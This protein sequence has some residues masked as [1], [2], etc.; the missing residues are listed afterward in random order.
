MT[1][2][3]RTNGLGPLLFAALLAS[4]I[5]QPAA[6]ID[7]PMWVWS[8][9]HKK[10]DVPA[11][12][13]YFRKTFELARPTSGQIQI[14]ADNAY[15]V[16]VNSQPVGRGGDWRRMNV[17]DISKA[18]VNGMN[19]VAVHV[20][21][22]DTGTAGLAARLIAEQQSD[23]VKV[24]LTDDTWRC[25]V[26]RYASWTQAAFPSEDWLAAQEFGPLGAT[27][28]WG[29]EVV[30]AGEGSRFTVPDGF[31]IERSM[32]H[33]EVGSLIAMTFNEN[34]DLIVSQERGPLLL[35][36][37]TDGSG[38]P[39]TSSVFCGQVQS[40]Q[41]LLALDGS[42]YAVGS[43][44]AG[45][46]LYRLTDANGDGVAE[47]VRPLVQFKGSRGEHGPHAVRLG[48][49][50]MIYGIVGNHASIKSPRPIP[51]LLEKAY[52]GDLIQPRYEDARGHA[53]GIPAPGGIVYR[54]DRQGRFTEV[55]ATGLRNAY[56]FAFTPDGDIVTFDS[57]MEW[58]IGAP[59]YRPTRILHATAG[60]DFGWRSGWA[61]WPSYHLD[62]LPP[63]VEVGPGSP[64]GVE[65]YQHTVFPKKYHGALL[66]C[67]WARGKIFAVRLRPDGA[68]VAGRSELFISGQPLNVT[69]LAVGPDGAVYF[70][71]GGR[72]TDGGVYRVRWTGKP[73]APPS[74]Q[75]GT[76]AEAIQNPQP[77]SA[78]ARRRIRQVQRAAGARWATSLAS[79]AADPERTPA[80]SVSA[81]HLLA[82]IGPYPRLDTLRPLA[83]DPRPEV[84]AKAASLML[85]ESADPGLLS[86]LLG[87]KDARV[88]RV[89][90]ES[91]ARTGLQADPNK[92]LPLLGE[93]DR[94]VTN[95]ARR[96]LE[97]LPANQWSELVLAES[98]DN[99]AFL[100]GS[101][102]LITTNPSS[103]TSAEIIDRCV[104]ILEQAEA[105]SFRDI[106]GA[107]RVA[108]LC[109]ARSEPATDSQDR[110]AAVVAKL[111]PTNTLQVDR[112]IVRL[113]TELQWGPAA[114]AF[115]AQV[116]AEMPTADKI[117][118][119]G[120]AA[121]LNRGWNTD[122]KFA[123]LKFFESTTGAEGGYSVSGYIEAF[124]RD[125]FTKLTPAERDRV[126]LSGHEWPASALSVLARLPQEL[127][128]DLIEKLI[129][130][131][132]RVKPLA[133]KA[134]VHR[135]LRVG[136]AAVLGRSGN[137]QAHQYL[138]S[139]YQNEPQQRE[140]VAMSL[141]QNPQG[142][143]WRVLVDSLKTV[144]GVAAREVLTSLRAVNQ[145][146]SDP[147]PYRQVILQGLKLQESGGGEAVQLLDHWAGGQPSKD[148]WQTRLVGW[149]QRYAANFPDAP[150]AELPVDSGRDRW[151]Y[152]ELLSFLR[153]PTGKE[154]NPRQGR[155]AYIKAQCAA[156]HRY[157]GEWEGLGPDLTH[158]NKRF[159]DKEILE[160]I[161][162][163]SH[164]VS[165]QYASKVVVTT[166]GKTYPGIV[167]EKPGGA[168]LVQFS[169][170]R[171]LEL[172]PDEI[173]SV[174][175]SATSVMP[176]GLLNELSLEE[177]ADLFAFLRG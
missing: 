85:G 83:K 68:T 111:Y 153:S 143:N 173:E 117:H 128:P 31:V 88:R 166:D 46:A 61:K 41:G 34:G 70:T 7:E 174:Q 82:T 50:G 19:V 94:F 131:D 162:Y 167:V 74:V 45:S 10:G 95:A 87:D 148:Q 22:T 28:P 69:D 64:T 36:R 165:D 133:E 89:A 84:R 108:Q 172:G 39:D 177:V 30:F 38:A 102:A 99:R 20:R 141:T 9:A 101:V 90:C 3:I 169:D 137:S 159:Q 65:V 126:L 1:E 2:R 75:A 81:L 135:R 14:T 125:F 127:P 63:M 161:V 112:E 160:S 42:V 142:E 93:D 48:P 140:T 26:R 144:E 47:D 124:A 138:H 72:A 33:D 113:L 132:R 158:V 24:L 51:G 118:L 80:D 79:V 15:E 13:C 154:G 98:T 164:V 134:D 123:F 17:H 32:T 52:E 116:A 43:G 171:Q 103:T 91:M 40:A 44:P 62:S 35:V 110:L 155:A 147:E 5:Q 59:W 21:N 29:D 121:R 168:L 78:W 16:F 27:L 8:P 58:D 122:S 56:D 11:V 145:R 130:L 96:L 156:C 176:Q 152:E 115:S 53:V 49:D 6:A 105:N 109:L 54:T 136:I 129:A 4:L 55:V 120:H 92:L 60:A 104:T 139:L 157:A 107:L 73:S 151:S 37:D 67:D 86:S 150:P 114:T 170:G 119:A 25:S 77:N 100:V 12:D 163:P 18:L 97:T 106:L 23:P 149:Q 57:D 146:P 71:T 175:P 66:A 76:V